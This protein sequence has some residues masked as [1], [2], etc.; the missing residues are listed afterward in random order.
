MKMSLARKSL[1]VQFLF[2]T[3]EII[4]LWNL[5]RSTSRS[6][7]KTKALATKP[8]ETTNSTWT[9]CKTLIRS[10]SRSKKPRQRP[11]KNTRH[12]LYS[13]R[14]WAIRKWAPL[15]RLS[16]NLLRGSK[17]CKPLPMTTLTS[18]LA[19]NPCSTLIAIS[20]TKILEISW[21][22]AY[23]RARLRGPW[24]NANLIKGGMNLMLRGRLTVITLSL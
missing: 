19:Y 12:R 16:R 23:K 11:L 24:Q 17:I 1:L 9:I 21:P 3:V 4:K 14:N 6:I 2:C 20:S 22:Q 15:K 13:T 8:S 5:T 10:H 18:R 7:L